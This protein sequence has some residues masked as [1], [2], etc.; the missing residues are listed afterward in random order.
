MTASFAASL[1][2]RAHNPRSYRLR[3]L[4]QRSPPS[5]NI[6]NVYATHVRAV[7]FLTTSASSIVD[8]EE[9]GRSARAPCTGLD[10]VPADSGPGIEM[11]RRSGRIKFQRAAT[12]GESTSWLRVP[13]VG[14]GRTR[15]ESELR[16]PD[17]V[18]RRRHPERRARH[19]LP[20]SAHWRVLHCDT[21]SAGHSLACVSD[22]EATLSRAAQP[23]LLE[24]FNFWPSPLKEPRPH[25]ARL[26][27]YEVQCGDITV[28]TRVY[29][30]DA[31]AA[32]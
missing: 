27:L 11:T 16:T 20:S 2:L 14:E 6:V 19:R 24:N 17:G 5:T 18:G 30:R 10:G 25:H 29:M 13:G 26:A 22:E 32:R 12:S 15:Y 3:S 7:I 4:A 31:P 9:S 28:S 8:A 1:C 23:V 21:A